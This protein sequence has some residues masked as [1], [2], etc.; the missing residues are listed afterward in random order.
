MNPKV[1]E[2]F[3]MACLKRIYYDDDFVPAE[4][5]LK[6]KAAYLNFLLL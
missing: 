6:I 5:N 4:Q 2:A 3:F 1:P